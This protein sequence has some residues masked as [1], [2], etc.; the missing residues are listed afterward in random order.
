MGG[1]VRVIERAEFM[2]MVFGW[3]ICAFLWCGQD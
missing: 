1:G 3:S 2:Q